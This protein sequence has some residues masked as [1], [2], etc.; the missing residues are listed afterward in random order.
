MRQSAR[1]RFLL[2]PALGVLLFL[3]L[4][5]PVHAQQQTVGEVRGRVLLGGPDGSGAAGLEVVLTHVSVDPLPPQNTVTDATGG[6]RFQDLPMGPSHGYIASVDYQGVAYQSAFLRAVSDERVLTA[7]VVVFQR[8]TSDAVVSIARI[9]DV[10]AS[11][12]GTLEVLE[13]LVLENSGDRTVLPPGGIRLALP[14]GAQDLAFPET[15]LS[16]TVSLADGELLIT[17]PLLPGRTELVYLFRIPYA[18]TAYRWEKPL[19]YPTV[20]MDLLVKDTGIEVAAMGLV[21]QGLVEPTPGERYQLWSGVAIDAGETPSV[22]FRGLPSFPQAPIPAE[23]TQVGESDFQPWL[24]VLA[25]LLAPLGAVAAYLYAVYRGRYPPA[26]KAL[27]NALG[28][29]QRQSLLRRMASLDEDLAAGKISARRHQRERSDA[30]ATLATLM[31]SPE[32]QDPKSLEGT[33]GG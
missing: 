32:S 9:H 11:E 20:A 30:K 18:G 22:E 24:R 15:D 1:E 4:G 7:E 29:R 19:V 33:S 17:A 16:D 28:D 13:L 8:T 21:F 31:G 10:V 26:T 23:T 5:V 25:V 27:E 12:P 14:D 2:R 3:A 6:F